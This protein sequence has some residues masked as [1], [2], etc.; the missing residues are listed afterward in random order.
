MDHPIPAKTWACRGCNN[1]YAQQAGLSR[2]KRTCPG[3]NRQPEQVQREETPRVQ[4]E[5]PRLPRPT[6]NV[7]HASTDTVRV[8]CSN[9]QGDILGSLDIMVGGG[10][11]PGITVFRMIVG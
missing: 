7:L 1:T 3:L 6:R 4:V 9:P 5:E 10:N 11:D 8:V 2:H